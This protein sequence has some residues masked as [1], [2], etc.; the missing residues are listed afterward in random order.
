MLTARTPFQKKLSEDPIQ[1]ATLLDLLVQSRRPKP[2]KDTFPLQMN[3]KKALQQT[4]QSLFDCI[5]EV[6]EM[7]HKGKHQISRTRRK[8]RRMIMGPEEIGKIICSNLKVWGKLFT[9]ET[10]IAQLLRIDLLCST[11]E[12]GCSDVYR[13]DVASDIGDG[14]LEEITDDIVKDMI[15]Q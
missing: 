7:G 12:W 11:E 13:R 1:S 3:S 4:R 15:D 9:D 5:K 10:N 8:Q 6:V 2:E 14:I